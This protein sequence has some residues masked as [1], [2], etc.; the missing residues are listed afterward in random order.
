MKSIFKKVIIAL[1][2]IVW[3]VSSMQAQVNMSN[4]ITLTVQKGQSIQFDL[5]AA[6][7]NT[8]DTGSEWK[9]DNRYYGKCCVAL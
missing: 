6:S 7:D 8:A 1:L 9:S 4:Y 5:K 3:G 2:A